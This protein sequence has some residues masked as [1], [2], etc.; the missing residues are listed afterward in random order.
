MHR[1]VWP[2]RYAAPPTL[3]EGNPYADGVWAPPGRY[4]VELTAG[5]QKLTRPL[6]VAPDPR[7]ALL[8]GA[9]ARQLGLARKVEALRERVAAAV[10]EADR[11]HRKLLEKGPVDLDARVV[12]LAGPQFGEVPTAAPPAGLDTLRSLAASLSGLA[13]AVGGADVDPSPDVVASLP[14]IEPAVEATLAA[15]RQLASLAP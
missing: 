1:F 2:L 15:W 6:T 12:A 5:G 14:K 3:G 8:A 11:L 9:Y 10:A 13:T 4:T 7:I